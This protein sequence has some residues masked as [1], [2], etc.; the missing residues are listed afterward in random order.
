MKV[1]VI[2]GVAG[3]MSAAAK[4]KRNLRDKVDITVYEK[5]DYVSYGACGRPYYISGDIDDIS[6]LIERTPEQFAESGIAVRLHCEAIAVDKENKEVT[7]RNLDTNETFTDKYDNLIVASGARVRKI[8]PLDVERDNLHV[9]RT[10]DDGVRLR[11]QLQDEAVEEVVVV[12]AGY[13]GLEVAEACA[14]QGKRVTV[15]EF[16]ARILPAMDPEISDRLADELEKNGLT[17]RVDSKVTELDCDGN[18]IKA[19][20]VEHAGKKE[21]VRADAVINC[22]GIIPNAEFIDVDKAVNGAILVDYNMR[23]SAENIYA[24]GDCSIMISQLTKELQ[25]APLGTTAN[26]QGR[27]IAEVLAGKEAPKFTLIGASA[28][29]IFAIDAAK[30]GLAE[31]EA[32]RLNLDYKTNLIT[33]NDLASYC[34]G[35]KITV[36]LVYSAKSRK[37]LGAQLVG[38]GVVT[39]RANCYAVAIT[40]GMTVDQFGF[41]DF[42]YSPPFSG[43]WDVTLIAATTAK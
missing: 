15:V 23:T 35:G 13:V 36:K 39:A 21:M 25:Y 10:P 4:L 6:S 14:K 41:L 9:V 33:G 42:C 26:K 8:R 27:M 22:A 38:N 30:V 29:R 24:A 32:Q 2:G 3:G 37:L 12:G 18:R 7:V 28:V 40:A 11:A 34:D 17:V 31:V 19:V 20:A 16:A 43:V 5:G 1:V